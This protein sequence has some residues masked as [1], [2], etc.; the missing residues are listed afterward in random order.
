[1]AR[2][3]TWRRQQGRKALSCKGGI[4]AK[5]PGQGQGCKFI[6]NSELKGCVW[7]CFLKQLTFLDTMLPAFLMGRLPLPFI[8][9]LNSTDA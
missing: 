5:E 6:D 4:E 2:V 9:Q 1:M 3:R 7:P 8:K